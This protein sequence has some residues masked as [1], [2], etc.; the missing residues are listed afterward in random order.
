M[1][2]RK[3]IIINSPR[4][5]HKC[6]TPIWSSPISPLHPDNQ[7]DKETIII[8]KPINTL[9]DLIELGNMYDATKN[10]NIDMEQLSRLVPSLTELNNMIGMNKIKNDMIDHILFYIQK[11]DVHNCM[12]HTVIEGPP[13]TGKTEVAK[14]IGKIYLALGVLRN[15]KFIK[16]TR[17]QLIGQYL[18]QT[19]PATQKVIN[20]ALG[21]VLF[22]DEVYSLGNPEKRDSYAKEC[23]DT[24][25]ENLTE[26]KND[27]ICIIAGYKDDIN[28]CFF[29]YNKGLERRF[30]IRFTIT[31]YTGEELYLIFRKKVSDNL[32]LLDENIKEDF[33]IDNYKFFPN[34]GGSIEILFNK[35]QRA[36][37]RRVFTSGNKSKLLTLEDLNKGFQVFTMHCSKVID[38]Q[39]EVWKQMFL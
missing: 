31:E 23:I 33:F 36:H 26:K 8:D 6:D 3:T 10:Y 16:A 28:K 18:G 15:D 38:C 11:L 1:T 25:N 32:W 30:P 4:K 5:I 29:A 13:G 2:K 27:F 24:I 37:A 20:S 34:Y 21:G 14:I 7:P 12:M 17:T 9:S 22:I 35:C 19:A 39:D